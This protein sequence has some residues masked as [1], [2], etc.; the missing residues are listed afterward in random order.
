MDLQLEGKVAFVS[1]SSRGIGRAIAKTLL[2]EGANVMINGRN[3]GRLHEAYKE[4][5]AKHIGMLDYAVGDITSERVI[6]AAREKMLSNW[7][8]IDVLV[9]NL[10]S[11]KL[12]GKQ[13]LDIE[14]WYRLFEV[15]LFSA[16]KLINYFADCLKKTCGSIVVVSSIAGLEHTGAP[17]AYSAAKSAM[18]PLVKNLSYELADSKV[19]INAVVPGNIYFKGGRWDEL[20]HEN[21]ALEVVISQNVPMQRFGTPEEVA[22]TVA[23][24][25][26]P[27]SSF[28]TGAYLVVDGGQTR[29]F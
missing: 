29:G 20:L 14:E 28:T 2:E 3:E 4:L 25:A 21:P 11:G 18:L 19:R 13:Q 22:N 27:A 23:F 17:F 26:S 15:N 12:L 1:A 8:R 7:K 24:L 5:N 6:T 16:V 9:A 10:G